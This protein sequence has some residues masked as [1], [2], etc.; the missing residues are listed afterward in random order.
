[1]HARRS[2]VLMHV[3]SL[4]SP[5]GIGDLGP[6]AYRFVDELAR[7]NQSVWQILPL[8]PT[9]TYAY[10]DPYHSVCALAGNPL[11]ISPELLVRDGLLT[12]SEIAEPPAFPTDHVDF[13]AVT[14]YKLSLLDT[15]FE[16]FTQRD[17]TQFS[18]FCEKNADWLHDYALFTVL[19][20]HFGGKPWVDWPVEFR[21]RHTEALAWADRELGWGV[22]RIKFRQ[23]LFAE[24]WAALHAYC[25][26]RFIQVF[27]DMPI[28][29]DHDGV[30]CWAN[31]RIFK[32]GE[33]RRPYVVSGVPPDYFSATGQLWG[34]PVFDWDAVRHTGYAWWLRRVER[35][36]ELF[37]MLRIDHFRGLVAYWEVPA[38][39][40]NALGGRWVEAPAREF[41]NLLMRR[42]PA[43]QLVAEDLG[44][45]TP[46]VR[47]VMRDFGFPG[48][49]IAQFAFGEDM[50]E[51]PYI[52]HNIE[53]NCVAYPGT[54]DNMPIRGWFEDEADP[55]TRDR[56]FGYLGRSIGPQDAPDVMCRLVMATSSRLAVLPMQD[57]LGLG[58]E[59]RMNR[60]GNLVGNWTWRA[61]PEQVEPGVFDYLAQLT[62]VYGRT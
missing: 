52:P 17:Q 36:F 1:M 15:A 57:L 2:G 37:D 6:E 40:E 20:E 27:G 46:D 14:E 35:N 45:I 51:H 48:M 58:A 55:E 39:A 5:F 8:T 3:T 10:N 12:E 18:R 56:L 32:L 11:M 59:A 54:H 22:Y 13:P 47:E 7:S 43:A 16:R 31:P 61:T 42:L 44:I 29:V 9:E 19:R 50:A 24:Q 62:R 25:R 41:F 38:G 33:D 4:P 60:P 21:D 30:E 34:T 28:Y 53:R 26:R 23:F 49:K